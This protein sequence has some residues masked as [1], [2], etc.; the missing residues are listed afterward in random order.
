MNQKTTISNTYIEMQKKLHENTNYGSTSRLYASLIAKI[1]QDIN[2]Q[3]LSDYGAGKGRLK[4]ELEALG[5]IFEYKPY[6]PA[7]PEYG[8]PKPADLCVCIDVLEH[9]EPEYLDNILEDLYKVTLSYGFFTIHTGPAKKILTDGRN[10][11][12]IQKPTS[13]WLPKLCNFFEILH[14]QKTED[15]KGFWIIVGPKLKF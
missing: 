6:D 11:H 9:S 2:A 7:F 10:A 3:S 13:F 15:L 12:L 1:I 5:I 8:A 4:G 14:L